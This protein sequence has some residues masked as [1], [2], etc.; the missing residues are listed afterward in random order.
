MNFLK[1]LTI[2]YLQETFFRFKDISGLKRKL[3]KTNISGRCNK[4]SWSGYA[5]HT[6]QNK[7]QKILSETKES[8]KNKNMSISQEDMMIGNIFAS[9][10]RSPKH[11]QQK[12]ELKGEIKTKQNN[13]S[14][15]H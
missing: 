2:S 8:I 1:S 15:K 4:K 3:W 10:S 7:R 12:L 9:N 14:Q 5:C 6:K 13:N 11:M